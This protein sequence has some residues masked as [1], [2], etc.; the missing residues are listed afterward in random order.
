MIDGEAAAEEARRGLLRTQLT[1]DPAMASALDEG[2]PGPPLLVTRLDIAGRDYYLVPWLDGR[3]IVAV[4]QIDA[5]SGVL[6]SAAAFSTPLTRLV[7]TANDARRAVSDRLGQAVFGEPELVWQPCREAASP[8]QPL[9]RVSTASGD[10][11][12]GVDGSVH[13]R[14]TTFGKGG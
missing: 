9:Y 11:F 5:Q 1:D 8:L 2:Q 13:L 3:G 4:A 6:A 14:L 7:M 12:V 10:A